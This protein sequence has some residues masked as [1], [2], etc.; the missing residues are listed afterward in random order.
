M[1]R[2]IKSLSFRRKGTSSPLRRVV[3]VCVCVSESEHLRKQ[4]AAD[5]KHVVGRGCFHF[6]QKPRSVSA[7]VFSLCENVL[8]FLLCRNDSKAAAVPWGAAARTARRRLTLGGGQV[9]LVCVI[10]ECCRVR[11]SLLLATQINCIV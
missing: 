8:I 7:A 3:C 4:R 1:K 5:C 6:S 9:R 10:G 2:S 11:S